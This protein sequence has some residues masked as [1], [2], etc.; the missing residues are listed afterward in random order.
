LGQACL[1]APRGRKL[2]AARVSASPLIDDLVSASAVKAPSA[3]AALTFDRHPETKSWLVS[4]E[5]K[6]CGRVDDVHCIENECWLFDII[7]LR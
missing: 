4:G 3:V 1:A 7:T 5:S 6:T 2:L